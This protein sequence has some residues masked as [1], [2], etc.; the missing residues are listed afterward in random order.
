[1]QAAALE[2]VASGGLAERQLGAANFVAGQPGGQGAQAEQRHHRGLRHCDWLARYDD[3][4]AH[5]KLDIVD[6]GARRLVPDQVEEQAPDVSA[7]TRGHQPQEL[8]PDLVAGRR[9][10]DAAARV[11]NRDRRAGDRVGIA[12]DQ[13][14]PG[15]G[16]EKL[17]AIGPVYKGEPG[18]IGVV[19]IAP[20]SAIKVVGEFGSSEGLSPVGLPTTQPVTAAPA[21][22]VLG[23]PMP[24]PLKYT[25]N[26]TAGEP[27]PSPYRAGE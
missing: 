16:I 25:P 7:A 27:A 3:L 23:D 14:D 6:V 2:T 18:R 17:M 12:A 1:M 4:G 24:W 5:A 26:V 13:P 15:L 19:G 10:D 22:Y 8:V 11:V 21:G 9:P 20:S